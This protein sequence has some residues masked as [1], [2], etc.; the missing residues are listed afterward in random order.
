M[1]E[2]RRT[3][4]AIAL[5]GN[6][7]ALALIGSLLL[8]GPR[9]FGP[10]SAPAA[11]FPVAPLAPPAA[12]VAADVAPDGPGLLLVVL[13]ALRADTARDADAMPT[14]VAL[15]DGGVG[16]TWWVDLLVPS[17]IGALERLVEG[18]APPA[19]AA[20]RDFGAAPAARGGWLERVVDA[21]GETFVAGPDLWTE[22]YGAW[23]T[24]AHAEA[25]LPNAVSDVRIAGAAR[26]ALAGD[27]PRVVVAHFGELDSVAHRHGAAGPEWRA[28]ARR[29]DARL[30]DV[31]DAVADERRV[32]VLADHGVTRRGGHAGGERVVRD[33]PLVVAGARSAAPVV[34]R[35]D[36]TRLVDAVL[37]GAD[38]PVRAAGAAAGAG[39]TPSAARA[40]P[41]ARRSS[42]APRSPSAAPARSRRAAC[43]G[44]RCRRRCGSR[45]RWRRAAASTR[46]RR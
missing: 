44:S 37:S 6:A 17:T 46:A 36:P 29:V 18:R 32:V 24:D 35:L 38:D 14:L 43:P 19:V 12:D 39:G 41:P 13:D 7:V 11:T 34:G 23:I 33:A 16:T 9:L 26:R 20:L 8:S 3:R 27:A 42:P 15:A 21:G 22:R 5:V 10:P 28:A 25:G 31:L 40:A 45:S 30:A 4:R 2:G 1:A